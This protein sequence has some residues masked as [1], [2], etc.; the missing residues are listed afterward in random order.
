MKLLKDI[1]LKSRLNFVLICKKDYLNRQEQIAW[2]K[3]QSLQIRKDN[4]KAKHG[5][6]AQFKYVCPT[7]N[8]ERRKNINFLK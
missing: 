3:F 4:D 7:G 6:L 1:N 2:K 5:M 8:R